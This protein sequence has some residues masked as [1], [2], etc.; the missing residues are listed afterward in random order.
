MTKVISMRQLSMQVASHPRIIGAVTEAIKVNLPSV[1]EIVMHELYPG[2][3]VRLYGHKNNPPSE[4]RA[5]DDAI[6]VEFNGRNI[7]ALAKKY[8]VSPS[9]V[10]RIVSLR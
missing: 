7:K 6:R 5:R 10:Y 2:E 4:R 1:I 3:E 8:G 9:Q